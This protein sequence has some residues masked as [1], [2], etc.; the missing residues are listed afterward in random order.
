[1]GNSLERGRKCAWQ[2]QKEL[3]DFLDKLVNKML[4]M[5][6]QF[7]RVRVLEFTE[8]IKVEIQLFMPFQHDVEA[9]NVGSLSFVCRFSINLHFQ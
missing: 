9:P 5:K 7:S 4:S 2:Q 6:F 3:K 8:A 1:M